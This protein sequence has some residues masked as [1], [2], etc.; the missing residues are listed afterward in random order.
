M[1]FRR[2]L[3]AFLSLLPLSLGVGCG[4]TDDTPDRP[5]VEAI[6]L[7]P[8]L[9]VGLVEGDSVYLFGD[10]RTVAVDTSGRIYVGD[11][12]GA[13]VRAYDE[14][15]RYLMRIAR[16]GEGP[17][18]ISGWPADIT[19]GPD[20]KLYLRDGTRIT[21]FA[22]REPGGIADSVAATWPLPGYGNLSSTRSRVGESGEYYYPNYLFR[23]DE[24]P[25]F[26]Y[27][28]FRG[29]ALTED[30]LEVPPYRGLSTRRRAFY[31]TGPGGGRLLDGLSHVPFAPVPVWDM[32]PAGTI[33]SSD[34]A[35]NELIESSMDGDTIR[36]IRIP[37]GGSGAIPVGER[38]DSARALQDRLD[39]IPVAIDEVL[40]MGE[41]VREGRLPVNLPPVLGLYVG[42]DGSI[43]VE[44]W[45]A[46]GEGDSRTFDILEMD[47][48]FRAR[49][50]LRAPL[51]RDPPPF[52]GSRYVV[53]VVTD[54]E[55]GVQR[56]VRFSIR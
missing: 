31:R 46:E 2:S 37:V 49:V 43:W 40:G 16:E 6:I 9:T 14:F 42:A 21:T 56:V 47:G 5:S 33:L 32:T 38:E 48:S 27:L 29:G 1:R 51:S 35:E 23:T 28:P 55:T 50:V 45:P 8:E 7:E 22:P 34:G 15:G 12:I 53:G 19:T 54:P 10:I 3:V 4:E 11:R 30:T 18:E 25:R 39:S 13:T 52:F 41:G 24:H 17:G 20:D 36:V 26:F 44:R